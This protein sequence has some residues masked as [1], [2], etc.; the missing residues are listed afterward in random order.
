MKVMIVATVGGFLP[1]F[2]TR[3][4]KI[5]QELGSEVHYA[6]NFQN[7]VYDLDLDAL[8][9]SGVITHDLDIQKSPFKIGRN[10]GAVRKL[11]DILRREAIDLIHCHTLMGSLT[12]RLAALSSGRKP[13]VIYT[14][15]GLYFYRGAPP[16]NWL[17]GYPLERI[18]ARITDKIITINQEDQIRAEKF[19]LR[20]NGRISRIYGAGVDMNR[21]IKKPG[22]RAAVREELGI[23]PDAFHIVTA[24]ELNR[25]KNHGVVIRAAAN[26]GEDVYCSICGRGPEEAA[27]RR[28][29]HE[30]GVESRVK[31]LGYRSDMPDI[32]Q[33]ADCFAFPS[34]REG[35]GIAA[36]EALACE[37]PVVAS[38]NR[39]TREYMRNGLNG[40]VCRE[41][42]AAAFQE[43]F[44]KLRADPSFLEYLKKGCR[45]SV[46]PFSS[47]N[48]ERI[49]RTVYGEIFHTLDKKRE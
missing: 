19:H 7:P 9:K 22:R 12:A 23:P 15:H 46:L 16:F 20:G 5:L 3:N 48:T 6:A 45:E 28:L 25:N 39:G 36:A 26:L 43:A 18:L 30:L 1:Q 38:D 35:F 8:H 34:F 4:V 2:E 29:I 47:D 21:F 40:L 11:R 37:V 27:L 13:Y 42:S 49:M 41:N 33:S 17:F 31:L 44:Q 32:L 14:T 24:A 10:L